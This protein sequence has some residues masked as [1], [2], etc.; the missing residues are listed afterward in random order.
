[1]GS[2]T[3]QRQSPPRT[4]TAPADRPIA[5]GRIT[6]TRAADV[7]MEVNTRR[8]VVRFIAGTDAVDRYR[9]VI[10][11]AGIDLTS[12]CQSPSVLWEH[13]KDPCRGTRPVALC[14]SIELGTHKGRRALI[15]A[16]K[17][18]DDDEFA[19]SIW[20]LYSAKPPVCRGWSVRVLPHNASPPTY[21][22]IRAR[23]DLN[24]C[25]CVYRLGDLVEVS[26]V[27]CPGNA[28]ALTLAVE[29]G[30]R[31]PQ[32]TLNILATGD[33][34]RP[35]QPPTSRYLRTLERV[36][37]ELSPLLRRARRR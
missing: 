32:S 2:I 13:G 6:I 31:F 5:P 18:N 28:N 34:A 15:G 16:A 25:D 29:R 3:V 22:E 11:P 4:R 30:L 12:F 10:D 14:E 21:E 20:R 27:S 1:M 35:A 23:P 9:T 26:C 36:A 37:W 7:A 8:K 19:E 33:P 24:A 17:F